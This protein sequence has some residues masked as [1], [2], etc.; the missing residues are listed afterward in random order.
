MKNN[1]NTNEGFLK[2]LEEINEKDALKISFF[3]GVVTGIIIGACLILGVLF[4]NILN[5]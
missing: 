3:K 4:F 1:I 5:L 2:E